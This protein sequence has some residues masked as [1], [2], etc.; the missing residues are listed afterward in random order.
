MQVEVRD[1]DGWVTAEDPLWVDDDLLDLDREAPFDPYDLPLPSDPLDVAVAALR[2]VDRQMARVLR[3]VADAGPADGLPARRHIALRAQATGVDVGFL[4]RA[5]QTLAAMPGTW[6]AFDDGRLSWSQLRGIVLEAR[7]L[8]VARRQVLDGLLIGL[9]GEA[10]DGEPDRL[11]EAC[12]DLVARLDRDI[13]EADEATVQRN[14][15]LVVQLG[16]DGWG[17]IAGDLAPDTTATVCEALDAA[18]DAPVDPDTPAATDQDG[19]VLPASLQPVRSRGQQLAEALHRVCSR[20]LSGSGTGRA[21]P[22]VTV[23][24]ALSDLTATD[25]A[26]L[27]VASAVTPVVSRLLLRTATG[28]RRTSRVLTRRLAEDATII[29]VFTDDA[30]VPVAVGD[31]H[32]PITEA[33]RRAV[34]ARD[35]GCRIPGCDVPAAHTDL[36]HVIPRHRGGPTQVANLVAVCRRHH[37]Q[38][39][40]HRWSMRLDPDGTLH[41][42]IGRRTYT[43]TPRLRPPPPPPRT[44]P[45][46]PP[47]PDLPF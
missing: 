7:R 3:A 45:A 11:V 24:A 31:S 10:T 6:Q 37:T 30:G 32:S 34:T 28:R 16:F 41:T 21:R 36:H 25:G 33:M 40:R 15:R 42:R 5:V 17:R 35:Q 46:H 9:I 4:H 38:L 22:Q 19:T 43:T 14:E 12:G 29:P 26:G 18:A 20:Y 44:E 47:D 39:T 27:G 1:P 2:V 8:T 13:A 23:V